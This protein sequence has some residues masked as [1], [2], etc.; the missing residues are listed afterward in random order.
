MQCTWFHPSIARIL[1][2]CRQE[3]STCSHIFPPITTRFDADLYLQLGSCGSSTLI[4]GV[5]SS[6]L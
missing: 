1:Y 2:I 6:E 3:G 5:M 4:Q